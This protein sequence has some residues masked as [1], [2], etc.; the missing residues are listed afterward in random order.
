[1][2]IAGAFKVCPK[3]MSSDILQYF[4]ILLAFLNSLSQLICNFFTFVRML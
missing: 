2:E 3:K 1:M 4:D